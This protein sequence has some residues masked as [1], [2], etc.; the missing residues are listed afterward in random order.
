MRKSKVQTIALLLATGL[1][2]AGCTSDDPRSP[3]DCATST[4]KTRE[5]LVKA[6]EEA[7]WTQKLFKTD[8]PIPKDLQRDD[9][10]IPM[11]DFTAKQLDQYIGW[12]S[13]NDAYEDS[14]QRALN[15]LGDEIEAMG[16]QSNCE[17]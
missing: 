7:I 15:D 5:R 13:A 12:K 6:V 1:L 10:P 8:K 3:G 9:Q 14:A 4:E 16:V 2:A 17:S 11:A